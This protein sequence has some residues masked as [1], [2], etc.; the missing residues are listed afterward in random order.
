M[1]FQ[2]KI[3]PDLMTL[4][5]QG[6]VDIG[7]ADGTSVIPAVSQGIPVRYVAT[8]YAQFPNV[9][10]REGAQRHPTPADLKGKKLGIPGKYGSSWIMLQALLK[11][12]GLTPDDLQIVLYPDFGQAAR[13]SRAR[14][15]PQRASRTTSQSSSRR[16]ASRRRSSAPTRRHRCRPRA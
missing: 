10:D 13:S 8:I 7:I 6:A 2:N 15:M 14:S 5:G 9:V 12:A 11:G 1:T 3:D 4:V 16:P